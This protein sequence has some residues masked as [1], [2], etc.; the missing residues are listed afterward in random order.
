[1]LHKK[2]YIKQVASRYG[3]QSAYVVRWEDTGAV[4]K[5]ATPP[6][7]VFLAGHLDDVA[8]F[9]RQVALLRTVEVVHG[10]GS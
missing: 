5:R 7:L 8:S 4:I 3:L 6:H 10:L 9:E 2:L 1:M